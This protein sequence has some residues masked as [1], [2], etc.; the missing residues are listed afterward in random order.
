MVKILRYASINDGGEAYLKRFHNDLDCVSIWESQ[1][2]ISL[3][4]T[5]KQTRLW[6]VWV[7]ESKQESEHAPWQ[8]VPRQ[9]L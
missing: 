7:V 4:K 6:S 3:P 2:S 1:I 5:H 9:G 8:V